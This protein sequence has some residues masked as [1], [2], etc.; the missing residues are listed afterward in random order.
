MA[1][2]QDA[3]LMLSTKLGKMQRVNVQA[4]IGIDESGE[5]SPPGIAPSTLLEKSGST[6]I[7]GGRVGAQ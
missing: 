4:L 2:L 7:P 6:R 1:D 3:Q 5:F